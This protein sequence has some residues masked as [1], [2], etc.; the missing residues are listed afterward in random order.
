M[1]YPIFNLLAAIMGINATDDI[2]SGSY[3]SPPTVHQQF[4]WGLNMLHSNELRC[5]VPELSLTQSVFAICS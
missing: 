2:V 1:F 4:L 3:N 5:V